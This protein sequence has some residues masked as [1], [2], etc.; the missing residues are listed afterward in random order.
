M[1][2]AHASGQQIG[3]PTAVRLPR[4]MRE[5]IPNLKIYPRSSKVPND[6]VFQGAAPKDAI[7]GGLHKIIAVRPSGPPVIYRSQRFT[8]SGANCRSQSPPRVQPERNLICTAEPDPDVAAGAAT[9]AIGPESSARP[10]CGAPPTR[11][12]GDTSD[13]SVALVESIVLSPA[14]PLI[15]TVASP[16]L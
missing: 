9:G 4:V 5:N 3:V 10:G 7:A 2:H 11:E 1:P 15:H 6:L 14:M 8:L 12:T 16:F 13:V